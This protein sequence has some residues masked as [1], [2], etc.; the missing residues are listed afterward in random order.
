MSRENPTCVVAR[1][2]AALTAVLLAVALLGTTGCGVLRLFRGGRGVAPVE[3]PAEAAGITGVIKSINHAEQ[4]SVWGTMLVE[5]GEQP[6]GAV[7]DKAM[8]TITE[9]TSVALADRWIPP[10]DLSVGMTVRVWFGGAVA[11]SYPVQGSAA[12]I[13]AEKATSP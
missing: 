7:S 9:K 1:A 3:V 13:Q 10:E 11:E 6:E 2:T 4:Q 8:V 5:G 12:F